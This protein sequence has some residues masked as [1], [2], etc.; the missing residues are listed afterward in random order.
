MLDLAYQSEKRLSMLKKRVKRCVCKYCGEPLTL[1]RIVFSDWEDARVEIFCENCGRIE[2][3]VEPEIYASARYFVDELKFN[4]FPDLDD[5][6]ERRQMNIARIS[7]AMAWENKNLGLLDN[8]GFLV[9]IQVNTQLLG[10]CIGLT[11]KDLDGVD[12]VDLDK[13]L[14]VHF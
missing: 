5:N 11:D 13:L 12:D 3:G 4:A 7:D 2:F 14:E 1:R 8:E 9:P 6:R 10:E